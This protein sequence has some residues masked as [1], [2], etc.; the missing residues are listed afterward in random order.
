MISV[1]KQLLHLISKDKNVPLKELLKIYDYRGY[2]TNSIRNTL[3]KLKKENFVISNTRGTYTVTELGLRLVEGINEKHIF[4]DKKF[5][6]NWCVVLVQ[7]PEKER[8]KRDAFRT[9]AQD[10]GFGI[11]QN[12]VYISPWDHRKKIEKITNMLNL[13]GHVTLI[14]GAIL[15]EPIIPSKAYAI[16]HLDKIEAV[17]QEKA[18]WLRKNYHQKLL[19]AEN[20]SDSILKL[21]DFYL[22]IGEVISN[23]FILDP[24]L[25]SELLPVNWLGSETLNQLFQAYD[26]ISEQ[27]PKDS[28]YSKFVDYR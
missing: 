21:F 23:L 12:G 22:E 28:P 8:K 13:K 3:S 14:E 20:S 11:L 7:V 17:Y 19:A 16:W 27:I 2:S 26:G 25:P 10:L 6:G 24:I 1:E 15:Q 5:D 4:Y 9:A 18:D